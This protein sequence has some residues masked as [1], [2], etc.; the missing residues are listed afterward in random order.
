MAGIAVITPDSCSEAGSADRLRKT[1]E[2][3]PPSLATEELT[4]IN[5]SCP[6]QKRRRPFHRAMMMAPLLFGNCGGICCARSPKAFP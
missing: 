5:A 4:A 6:G 1:D 2:I 3:L